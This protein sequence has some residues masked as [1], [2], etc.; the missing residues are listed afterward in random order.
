MNKYAYIVAAN[1]RYLPGLN[2]LLNS[3][4]MV[5]NKYPVFILGY[6]LPEDYLN[7]AS[8]VLSYPIFTT[9][10]KQEEVEFL[11][12]AEVLMRKRYSYP[13]DLDFGSYE[14]VCIL[15]ADMFFAHNAEVYLEIAHKTGLVL[16]CGL[17]QK[18][19][20]GDANHQYPSGSGVYLIAPDFWNAHDLCC[21][22]LFVGP[23]WYPALK[24]SWDIVNVEPDKRFKAPDM[25]A[26]NICL[27]EA[28]SHDR[29]ICLSQHNWTGLHECFMKAHTRAVDIHGKLCTE[30][31]E[32]IFVVHGQWWNKTWRGWQIENQLG[33]VDREF[34]GSES[35]KS[36]SKASFEHVL[37]RYKM[38]A[39][40]HKININDYLEMIPSHG[41]AS[42]V[43]EIT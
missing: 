11:G 19:R 35:Y 42:D 24:K 40:S 16:G 43:M 31:G 13:A 29:T 2:A 28:G 20:Y 38:A 41:P 37:E 39:V 34:D 8:M 21:A 18:R 25:D 12:E 15:D 3:L 5:G 17:E 33:M 9:K 27:L 26:L 22:P 32:E 7:K 1:R 10:I 30:D 6:D 14:A 36:R 23:Q 4:D